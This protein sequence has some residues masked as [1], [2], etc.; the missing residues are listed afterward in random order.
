MRGLR[1]ISPITIRA[2]PIATACQ[3]RVRQVGS[4]KVLQVHRVPVSSS[5]AVLHLGQTPVPLLGSEGTDSVAS[6]RSSAEQQAGPH[7]HQQLVQP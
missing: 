3:Q 1:S 7:H 2:T 5:T 4:N 6:R